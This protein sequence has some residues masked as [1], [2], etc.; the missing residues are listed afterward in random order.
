MIDYKKTLAITYAFVGFSAFS[1]SDASFKWLSD[2][3]PAV[4]SIFYANLVSLFLILLYG[5]IKGNVFSF[6]SVGNRNLHIVRGFLVTAQI[7]TVIYAFKYMPLAMIY[8]LLFCSPFITA[9]SARFLFK[10]KLTVKMLAIISMGFAGA[11]IV[12]RPDV[13]NLTDIGFVMGC[14][15]AFMVSSVNLIARGIG[16]QENNG[17]A[18]AFYAFLISTIITGVVHYFIGVTPPVETIPAFLI[19]IP[20]GLIGVVAVATGFTKAPAAV[21]APIQY[22]QILWGVGLGW[23]L[24]GDV[25]DLYA[26]IGISIIIISGLCLVWEKKR[27]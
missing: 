7:F 27:N 19:I 8:T 1:I 6:W 25:P 21:V 17:Y 26:A 5:L 18:F 20:F 16:D 4:S 22:T 23:L 14:L 11:Y 24:F 10:E 15:G 12:F 3:I 2:Y 9:I 13:S